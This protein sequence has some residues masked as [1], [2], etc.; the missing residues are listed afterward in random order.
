MRTLRLLLLVAMLLGPVG[1][2]G[3]QDRRSGEV[4]PPPPL[5]AENQSSVPSRGDGLE[6]EITITSKGA[7]IHE[8]YRY[9]GFLYRVKVT[10]ARGP[11]YYLIYDERGN[12]RRSDLQPDILIPQW[13]IKR[14]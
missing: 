4:P 6:P 14:F 7:E 13:V 1:L 3:A 10:P 9:N 12:F 2:A 5:P 8:E 11:A